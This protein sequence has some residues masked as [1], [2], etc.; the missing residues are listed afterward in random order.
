M[1]VGEQ[2]SGTAGSSLQILGDG[3]KGWDK[4][5]K[6]MKILFFDRCF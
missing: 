1:R 6:N 5:I 3:K 2:G 4:N